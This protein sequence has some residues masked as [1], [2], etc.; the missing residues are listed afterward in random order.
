[1]AHMLKHRNRSLRELVLD[2]NGI[3]ARGQLS[4]RNAIFDDSSFNALE[5]SNHILQ[6]YFYNPRSVFG[7]A[8]MNDVLSSHA[9]NLRCRSTKAAVTKKL[10]RVL[11]KKYRVMLRFESFLG[12]ESTVLPHVLGWI[13]RRCD[14]QMMYELKPILLNLLEGRGMMVTPSA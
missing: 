13:A 2:N 7:R 14:V 10:K 1:M 8:V 12:V 4:L 5:Q 6:S 3:S 9:A 11:H